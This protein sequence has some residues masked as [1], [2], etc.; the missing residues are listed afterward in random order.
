[1]ADGNRSSAAA[2]C[3]LRPSF[4]W[5]TIMMPSDTRTLWECQPSGSSG[6]LHDVAGSV[7]AP[8]L[9]EVEAFQGRLVAG[10]E[11]DRRLLVVAVDMLEPGTA[12]HCQIV[13]L[14]PIEALAV[15]DRVSLALERRDQQARR[16]P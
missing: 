2:G 9:E 13:E 1:M 14:L 5:L 6:D 15:D 11:E 12:R 7:A 4:S 3:R 16:L 8:L 10:D